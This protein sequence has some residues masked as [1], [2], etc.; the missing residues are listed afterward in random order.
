MRRVLVP[1]A[2][3]LLCASFAQA[4]APEWIKYNSAEGRYAVSLPAEPKISTQES[5][6]A[7]GQKFLQYMATVQQSD[8]VYLV[9]YFDHVPGTV[10]YPDKARDGMVGA[11][12]GTLVNERNITLSG[13]P[14]REM[15]VAA[16]LQGIDFILL[17]KFWDT[18]QRVYVLQCIFPKLIES[19]ATNAKAAKYFDSFQILSK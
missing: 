7:D 17:A 5:T 15:R 3:L 9:G 13:Y 12:K 6:T 10:F 11:V 4:Q 16:K 14:G 2:L 1:L 19:D 8:L 18:D